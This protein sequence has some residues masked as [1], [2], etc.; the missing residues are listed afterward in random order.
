VIMFFTDGAFT[1][2]RPPTGRRE[3]LI[4]RIRSLRMHVW[5]DPGDKRE[6]EGLIEEA[7]AELRA[8][9]GGSR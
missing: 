2:H 9:G 6:L 4:E 5:A 3:E 7:E 1:P 8:L